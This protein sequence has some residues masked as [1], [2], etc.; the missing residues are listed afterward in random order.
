MP[1]SNDKLMRRK[2]A[3]KKQKTNEPMLYFE[4]KK[5]ICGGRISELE[6]CS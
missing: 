3:Q 5:I 2:E 1:I 4:E 6:L